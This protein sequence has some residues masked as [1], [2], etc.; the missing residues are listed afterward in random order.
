MTRGKVNG[1]QK[2]Y[3]LI[4]YNINANGFMV[5]IK[6]LWHSKNKERLEYI[7]DSQY[8]GLKTKILKEE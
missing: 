1:G 6:V 7:R 5:D 8:Q 4:T 2:M 3:Y